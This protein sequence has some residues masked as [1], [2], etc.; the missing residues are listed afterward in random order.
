MRNNLFL[1][2]IACFA[3]L[4]VAS[5]STAS[6]QTTYT[7]STTTTATDTTNIFHPNGFY[8]G[9]G[10]S[11]THFNSLAVSNNSAQRLT[12]ENWGGYAD[13]GYA[14]ASLPFQ[15][16]VSYGTSYLS[17]T[18]ARQISNTRFFQEVFFNGTFN[19]NVNRFNLFNSPIVPFVTAGYG[20]TNAGN[21]VDK[22]EQPAWKAGAGVHFV[23]SKN[24]TVD[25]SFN[26]QAILDM[27]G[28]NST[29]EKDMANQVML[30]VTFYLDE[31]T[32][33]FL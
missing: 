30:G 9:G 3:L 11:Y 28:A 33:H 22:R 17:E 27:T 19:F 1:S 31:G 8:V 25:A 2:G 5:Y 24:M 4:S 21:T 15:F 23:T 26:H 20:F 12:P 16:D 14:L 10:A 32:T 18:E 6:A 29:E 7:Q 13:V